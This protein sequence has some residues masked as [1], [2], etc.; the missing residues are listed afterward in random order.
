MPKI[1]FQKG[2]QSPA[3]IPPSITNTTLVRKSVGIWQTK[4]GLT[5][6]GFSPNMSNPLHQP[7]SHTTLTPI[8][9]PKGVPS[10]CQE[11]Q[12]SGSPEPCTTSPPEETAEASS[13][14]NQKIIKPTSAFSSKSSTNTRSNYMPTA[15]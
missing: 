2:G 14:L 15:L 8:P 3:G 7:A 12:G 11:T 13:S 6:K 1:F 10:T 9:S 4:R 5:P